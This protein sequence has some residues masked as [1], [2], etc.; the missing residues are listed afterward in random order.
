VVVAT[1]NPVKITAVKN[2]FNRMFPDLTFEFTG[3]SSPSGVDDQPMSDSET[4]LGAQNRANYCKV[5]FPEYDYWVGVE[6][7]ID[8]VD[9]EM[10]AFAWI[11]ILSQDQSSKAKSGTFFLPEKVRKLV[12]SGMELGEADDV[13]FGQSNSKQKGGAVGLLTGNIIDRKG[14]YEEAV[15]LALIPFKNKALYND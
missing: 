15:I 3:K 6:G 8:T 1:Q 13:V 7:G 5:N 2:A 14:L 10:S 9:D 4:L 12:L 11:V